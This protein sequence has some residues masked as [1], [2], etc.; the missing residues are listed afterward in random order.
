M[1]LYLEQPETAQFCE[2]LYKGTTVVKKEG[3]I[4]TKGKE[5]QQMYQSYDAAFEGWRTTALAKL[6]EGY[7]DPKKRAT[8][9]QLDRGIYQQYLQQQ[10]ETQAIQWL[11][12]YGY[13][14]DATLENQL[15]DYYV[16]RNNYAAAE[17]YI[18]GNLQNSKNPNVIIRQIRYLTVIN[19]MLSRFMLGNLPLEITAPD[20]IVYYKELAQAQARLGFFDTL[21]TQLRIIKGNTTQF[22]YLLHLL[23]PPHPQ[24]SQQLVALQKAQALLNNWQSNSPNQR[25]AYQQ[26]IAAAQRIGQIEIATELQT[27]LETLPEEE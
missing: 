11:G 10:Q 25:T 16:A 4:G 14:E 3:E 18:L 17:K 24:N 8:K 6:E 27:V 21:S 7:R 19:P 13:L 23:D 12:Y 2:I 5:Q 1:Q 15:V 20:P 26:L 9:E 22:T